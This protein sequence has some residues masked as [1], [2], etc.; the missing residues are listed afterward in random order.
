MALDPADEA[1]L[2]EWVGSTTPAADLEAALAAHGG[3]RTLAALRILRTRRAD[4]LADPLSYSIRGDVTV[5]ATAN[6]VAVDS[7]IAQLEAQAADDGDLV[8]VGV[9]AGAG[10]ERQGTWGRG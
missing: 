6:L 3:V 2:R 1:W 5:N 4:L 7:T 8:P 9:I 10:L